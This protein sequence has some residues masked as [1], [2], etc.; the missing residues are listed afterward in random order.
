V[1]LRRHLDF[2]RLAGHL[3]LL[4]GEYD[5]AQY[6]VTPKENTDNDKVFELWASAA[7]L[8]VTTD[9][10]VD[11]PLHSK[12]D[13]PDFIGTWRGQRWGFALKAPHSDHPETLLDSNYSSGVFVVPC[14]FRDS[15]VRNL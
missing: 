3:Q 14:S 4:V 11:D 6:A 9:C 1:V 10:L 13:N 5:M 2:P 12:G 8:R 15:H 7:L